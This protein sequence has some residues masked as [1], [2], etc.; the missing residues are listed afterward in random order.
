WNFGDPADSELR[1]RAAADAA[2]GEAALEL[3]TQEARAQGLQRRFEDADA[4]LDAVEAAIEPDMVVARMRLLL[5]R[6]R[7]RRSSGDA[8]AAR[9]LFEAAWA[10]GR[11]HGLDAQAVDAAHMVALV[12]LV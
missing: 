4:T 5:E 12:P 7:V 10:H 3:R 8:A 6:G 11:E 2:A 9:S 1:F